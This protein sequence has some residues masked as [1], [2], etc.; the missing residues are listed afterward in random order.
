M[1][2][3][4][5]IM[6]TG[7]VRSCSLTLRCD[8]VMHSKTPWAVARDLAGKE[9]KRGNAHAGSIKLLQYVPAQAQRV[10]RLLTPPAPRDRTHNALSLPHA[11]RPCMPASIGFELTN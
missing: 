1:L 10:V 11:L 3:K 2:P 8:A 4:R 7:A 9:K 6:V 5:L